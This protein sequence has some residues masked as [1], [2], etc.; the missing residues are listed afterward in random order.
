MS[1]PLTD[2][3]AVA[4]DAA[5]L[6]GSH[7][8]KYFGG[9]ID[10]RYKTDL[11]PVTRADLESEEILRREIARHYPHHAILGEEAGETAGT[12]AH[13]HWIIDPLDG[14]KSFI[15]GVPLYGTLVGVEIDGVPRVGA[16]Y[17]P[18]TDEM[19]AA[20]DG[21]GCTH[22]GRPAR[23]SS[24]DRIEDA[25]ILTTNAARCAARWDGFTSLN[26]RALLAAGWG[27]AY[28]H[29]MVATG[30]ADV[31]LDPR[32]SPWD[33]AALVPILHEAGGRITSWAGVKKITAGDALSTNG[34]LH[35]LMLGE[36]G[37][38]RP[39]GSHIR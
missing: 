20:A 17:L 29:V 21:L 13:V 34:L 1:E 2:L 30:R 31:M 38:V 3:L 16:V 33:V 37:D 19:I 26:A 18:A 15:R 6:A 14:T 9:P 25:T 22:N 4:V 36:M 39:D 12:N 7:T 24:V 35:E 5:R 27:D 10:I 23:V 28:G 32:V 11:S 8:L